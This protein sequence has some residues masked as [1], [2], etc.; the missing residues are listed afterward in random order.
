MKKHL[1]ATLLTLALA[2][3]LVFSL[4]GCGGITDALNSAKN[5][6]SSAADALSSAVDDLTQT[7]NGNPSTGGDG[8]IAQSGDEIK[9]RLTNYDITMRTTDSDGT[10]TTSREL[11]TRDALIEQMDDSTSIT[12]SDYANQKL[13]FLDTEDMTGSVMTSSSGNNGGMLL[14]IL[15][16]FD[17]IKMLVDDGALTV[18]NAGA[19]TIAGRPVTVY[20][21]NMIGVNV[22]FWIDNEYGMTMKLQSD[23]TNW[24]VTQFKAGNVSPSDWVNLSDYTI[25]G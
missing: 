11:L 7:T 9:A 2:L 5:A 13:Y 22:K 16:Y 12:Y 1:G 18:Q 20:T 23:S 24:E 4:S 10:S 25:S 17:T 14:I 8:V 21:V 19:D 3:V 15:C 6:L